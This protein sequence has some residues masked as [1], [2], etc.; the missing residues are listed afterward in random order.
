[1]TD[2]RYGYVCD[3]VTLE[4]IDHLSVDVV[5]QEH[6][7]VKVTDDSLYDRL[8]IGA[9]VRILPNHA[10]LT[11]APYQSYTVIENNKIIGEWAKATGW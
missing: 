11:A 6:G 5:H 4:R 1:L 9:Q 8:P 2:A 7:T 10:C 3:P